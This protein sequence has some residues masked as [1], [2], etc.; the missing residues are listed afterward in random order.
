MRLL[1]VRV[2]CVRER[3]SRVRFIG[4]C[5]VFRRN[6]CACGVCGSG[7]SRA[8]R[9]LC[10]LSATSSGLCAPLARSLDACARAC[11]RWNPRLDSKWSPTR[12]REPAAPS[13]SPTTILRT[14]TPP[15]RSTSP[16]PA[17][18]GRVSRAALSE[19][20]PTPNVLRPGHFMKCPIRST[21][22]YNGRR[23]GIA[24]SRTQEPAQRARVRSSC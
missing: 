6:V 14:P 13:P 8:R 16:H 9:V 20:A 12:V 23:S 19:S 7:S 1:G 21:L 18:L 3:K 22:V 10:Q 11:Q 15:I 24:E 17:P 5:L 4:V 2:A